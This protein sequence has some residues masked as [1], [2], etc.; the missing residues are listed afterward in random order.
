MSSATVG[1]L[2]LH[3]FNEGRH[4]RLWEVLGAH[5][6]P[7]GG[8]RF[9]VWAPNATGAQVLGDWNGWAGGVDLLAP[10]GN[11]GVWSGVIPAAAAGHAYKFELRSREG[12][13]LVRCDPFARQAEVPPRNAGVI[14][15]PSEHRWG[16][17]DW[18]RERAE[19]N[20][21]RCAIYELHAGSWRRHPDGRPLGYRE[22]A[23]PLA[24]HVSE[25]GFT[26]VEF[27]PLAWHPYGGS[28]GY[29]VT[30]FYAPDSRYGSPDELRALIDVLHQAGIG[31]IAD[32]VP[33]HF[34]RDEGALARFDGTPLYEH[35]DPRRGE[36]PDWGTYVFN[37][38][39]HE[40]RNFLVA[41][42]L[43]W[44]EEF[45]LD[46]LRVDAV[47]S[48]LYL[49][50]SREPGEWIPNEHG[51]RE[52]L[53]ACTFLRELNEAVAEDHP[54]ALVAAEDSTAW[55]GVTAATHHGGL[56][57][58]RKWNLGWMHDTLSFLAHDPIHRSHHHG[59]MTFPLV[60]AFD[61][62]WVLPLSHDEVV[63]GKGSLLS[64]MPGDRWQQLANLRALLAWQWSL[65]GQPLVFM[66]TELA[67]PWEWA[68]NGEL[69]WHLSDDP[70]H[71]GVGRLI[72]DLN[73]LAATHPALWVG[74]DVERHEG[75]HVAW[76]L[77]AGDTDHSVFTLA[78]RDPASGEC[79]IVAANL[80]P[81]P[82]HG[83]RIGVPSAG[84]WRE[85]LTTDDRRYGGSGLVN[86]TI[87]G[88]P[89]SPWQGQPQ[90]VLV[91][92]P[93]LGITFLAVA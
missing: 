87:S 37:H 32:W 6:Q 88:D 18:R 4:R 41:N 47:A 68:E 93:P 11:S 17:G 55:P 67:T 13:G 77:D 24:A 84:P 69:A 86:G 30:G 63:H 56:G 39:R 7:G 83:Y 45:H 59:Q 10:L 27:L 31:V 78:R 26:H 80:T 89:T 20:S 75:Q 16:D 49:D 8:V 38:G 28:W 85:V 76:W 21:G 52:D 25:L 72:G 62:R 65:P 91:T 70:G 61:E 12:R 2:D 60:Y 74:D 58:G 40:V 1:E 46:G 57:F 92:M 23:E 66:G 22:L 43:Y 90:S 15:A 81:V 48:M 54:G 51:G 82:R 5:H 35:A 9:S 71:G 19:R 34:P 3:L 36:H 33:A 73:C 50:Y 42:A 44:L 29:Q 79:V 14:A 64:K 53:E